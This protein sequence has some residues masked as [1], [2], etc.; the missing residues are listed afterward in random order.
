MSCVDLPT[1]GR[2]HKGRELRV[3]VHVDR[4]TMVGSCGNV[5]ARAG[6]RARLSGVHERLAE[7]DLVHREPRWHLKAAHDSPQVSRGTKHATD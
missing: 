2:T 4:Y 3:S 5:R 7:R 6:S 1:C